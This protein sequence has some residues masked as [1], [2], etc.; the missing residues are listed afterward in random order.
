MKQIFLLIITLVCSIELVLANDIVNVKF[1]HG[2][3]TAK[4]A[5]GE[6][7]SVMPNQ[8]FAEGTIFKTGQSSYIKLVFIDKSELVMAPNSLIKIASFSNK[9]S[10]I[11]HLIKGIIRSKV[12]KDY[13][14]IDDKNKSKLLIRTNYAALGIRGTYFQVEYNEENES[15]QLHMFQGKVVINKIDDENQKKELNQEQLDK[16]LNQKERVMVTKGYVT[17]VE[18]ND[19]H[20]KPP[21]SFNLNKLDWND[22]KFNLPGQKEIDNKKTNKELEKNS[23][24][25]TKENKQELKSELRDEKREIKR[26]E[27]RRD[28]IRTE[29]RRED[30]Q[31]SRNGPEKK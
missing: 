7:K 20:P 25:V 1:V 9:D 26:E 28:E 21:S 31:S 11:I 12:T 4:L 14:D 30:I 3:V 2:S 29:K 24:D 10:G 6:S 8:S 27:A 16:I 19:P 17:R 15:T 5:T 22:K 23:K 13:M 18:R